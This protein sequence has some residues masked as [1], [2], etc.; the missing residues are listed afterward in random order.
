MVDTGD[1]KSPGATR[2]GSNPALGTKKCRSAVRRDKVTTELISKNFIRFFCR[3]FLILL[4][5]KN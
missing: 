5:Y 3:Y 2:A 4:Y 1:L